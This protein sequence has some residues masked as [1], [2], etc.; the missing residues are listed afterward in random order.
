M[1]CDSYHKPALCYKGVSDTEDCVVQL[2]A[3]RAPHMITLETL[4]NA[5]PITATEDHPHPWCWGEFHAMYVPRI[6]YSQEGLDINAERV[7]NYIDKYLP[8]LKVALGRFGSTDGIAAKYVNWRVYVLGGKFKAKFGRVKA[9][10]HTTATVEL[11]A[12]ASIGGAV[13]TVRRVDLIACVVFSCCPI[14]M[15]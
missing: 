3:R 7:Q 10:S 4:E 2:L 14:R 9:F 1:C 11:E 5:T 13:Q 15:H 12:L 8:H 6:F